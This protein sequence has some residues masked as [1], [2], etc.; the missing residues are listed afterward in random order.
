MACS[1]SLAPW[2]AAVDSIIELSMRVPT[3]KRSWR[4]S[5]DETA[6][7]PYRPVRTSTAIMPCRCGSPSGVRFITIM[8]EKAWI[9]VSTV[10]RLL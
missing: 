5:A 1:I 4:I 3:P 10:G 7:K 2:K 6:W 9:S 8:P